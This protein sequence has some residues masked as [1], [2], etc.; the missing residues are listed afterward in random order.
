M[1]KPV[2][3]GSL[4]FFWFI[5]LTS[6]LG[7]N[8]FFNLYH[9]NFIFIY[10]ESAGYRHEFTTKKHQNWLILHVFMSKYKCCVKN[11]DF[12]N[13]WKLISNC[14]YIT[15]CSFT[16]WHGRTDILDTLDSLDIQLS[17]DIL[18]VKIRLKTS[19]LQPF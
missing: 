11:I 7:L 3:K 10:L 8:K 16:S 2:L 14:F 6:N 9:R 18:F 1:V 5:F 17:M 4:R 13:L 15:G 19:L 12:R